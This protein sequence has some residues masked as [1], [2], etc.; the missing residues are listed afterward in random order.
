MFINAT[1][2]IKIRNDFE[3]IK[4]NLKIFKII[5]KLNEKKLNIL[6]YILYKGDLY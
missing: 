5:Q 4:N 3:L 1:T 6:K 2:N